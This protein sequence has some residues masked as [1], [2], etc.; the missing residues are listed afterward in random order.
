MTLKLFELFDQYISVRD[1]SKT[2]YLQ[3]HNSKTL[4]D[5]LFFTFHPDVRFYRQD[6]PIGYKPNTSD[7][8]G[9]ASTNIYDE[10]RKLYLF[11]LG[12]PNSTGISLKRRDE[13]L[14]QFLEGLEAREAQV[15]LNMMNKD[16]KISGLDIRIVREAF[17][18]LGL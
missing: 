2:R 5:V 3:Y 9:L 16:L 8:V 11:V 7:P 18:E 12:H 4:R 15:V 6:A 14:L 17:P 1:D 13:L 10:S